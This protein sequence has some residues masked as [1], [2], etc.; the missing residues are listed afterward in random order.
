[1]TLVSGVSCCPGYE[2][3]MVVLSDMMGEKGQLYLSDQYYI[4]QKIPTVT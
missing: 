3:I 2:L 4:L 1:M